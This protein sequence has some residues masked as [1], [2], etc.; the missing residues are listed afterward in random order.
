MFAKRSRSLTKVQRIKEQ[1][2]SE[3]FKKSGNGDKGLL[4]KLKEVKKKQP[5]FQAEGL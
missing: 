1:I 4:K 5:P 2:E 3:V